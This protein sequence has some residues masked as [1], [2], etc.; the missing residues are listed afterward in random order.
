MGAASFGGAGAEIRHRRL[1]ERTL[2]SEVERG[3]AEDKTKTNPNK[4]SNRFEQIRT[5]ERQAAA[6]ESA[7]AR[8]FLRP[9]G[10]GRR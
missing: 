1:A 5:R 2:S 4:L 8:G 10:S 9:F 3:E 6:L 7:L